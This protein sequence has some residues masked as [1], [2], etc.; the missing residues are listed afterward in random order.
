MQH[1]ASVCTSQKQL[2]WWK[3]R[4]NNAA[5]SNKSPPLALPREITH[6]FWKF[7]GY[8]LAGATFA[9]YLVLLL[10]LHVAAAQGPQ[11]QQFTLVRQGVATLHILRASLGVHTTD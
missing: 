1:D 3:W 4:T 10:L 9:S 7:D 11:Q 5:K 8:G 6:Q 2:V